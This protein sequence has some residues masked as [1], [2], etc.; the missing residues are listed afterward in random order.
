MTFCPVYP[1]IREIFRIYGDFYMKEL[2]KGYPAKVIILFALP[3]MLGNIFQQMYNI[4]DSKIVSEYVSPEAF[5]AV[6]ATAVISNT[7]IGFINGLTQGFSILIAR[8]FGERNFS[9]LRNTW[10][11]QLSLH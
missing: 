6:G 8:C 11:E 3:L 10:P 7:L 5:A 1:K 9:S 4:T 2:T